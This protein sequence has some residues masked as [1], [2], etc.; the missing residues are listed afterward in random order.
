[1]KNGVA[2][3]HS[4]DIRPS[5][6][7]EIANPELY[8]A[9]LDSSEA[10]LYVE[11]DVEL[12]TGFSPA[13]VGNNLPVG[14]IPVD[15]IF[16][17]MRKVNFSVEPM[18]IGHETSHERLHLE[19]WTDGTI[20]PASA[21]S[22]SGAILLEQLTPFSDYGRVSKIDEEK[23][24]LRAAISDDVYNM[25][26]EQMNLSV[27]AMNCLRRS[28]INTIGELISKGEKELLALRNFGQKSKEEIN[29]RLEALGVSFSPPVEEAESQPN[30][31][32]SKSKPAE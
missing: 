30:N 28:G 11:F 2:E 32:P 12:G 27:R 29:E 26:V 23:K 8:L 3:V 14:T 17:P 22:R 24:A 1:M 18:H 19:V 6:E 31:K 7:F 15:A 4:G 20:T 5:T 13:K 10:R 25:P 16:T 9:T 21:I